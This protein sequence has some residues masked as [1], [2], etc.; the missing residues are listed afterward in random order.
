[1][2]AGLS[3]IFEANSERRVTFRLNASGTLMDDLPNSPLDLAASAT[4]GGAIR[5]R[6]IYNSRD[7]A[8]TTSAVRFYRNAGDGSYPAM[9]ADTVTRVSEVRNTSAYYTDVSGLT[10]GVTYR[11]RARAVTANG[12]EDDNNVIVTAVPDAT[13]PSAVSGASIEASE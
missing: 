4:A 10:E 3:S 5:L 1:M 11:F 2:R 7:E 13:A 8:G 6:C 12:T 9:L